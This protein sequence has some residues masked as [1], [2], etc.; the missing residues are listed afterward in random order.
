MTDERMRGRRGGLGR[1]AAPDA[2]LARDLR[3]GMIAGAAA[4]IAMD[5][6]LRTLFNRE[7]FFAWAR[8]Q[9][10][11]RGKPALRRATDRLARRLGLDLSRPQRRI[12][13][14]V[15]QAGLGLGAGALYAVLRRRMP[16]VRTGRGLAYGA[17]V[18]LLLDEGL[19][20]L[21]GLTPGP[22]DFPWQTHARG[23]AGHLAYGA[24][25]EAVMRRLA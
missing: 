22:S 11:R 3:D 13:G 7:G 14:R 5:A 23:L 24:V 21:L 20:P 9:R 18:S 8:E 2:R 4:G 25:L 19:N 16:A 6:V 10:A 15:A 1:G 17:A 12:A